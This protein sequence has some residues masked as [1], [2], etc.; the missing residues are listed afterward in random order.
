MED[1]IEI[2]QPIIPLPMQYN[3]QET[4]RSAYEQ[5]ITTYLYPSNQGNITGSASNRTLRW[6]VSAENFLDG[7][8]SYLSLEA[9]LKNFD[10]TGAQ[11]NNFAY[12]T[13]YTETW[14]KSLTIYSNSGLLISQTRN[15]NVLGAIF[16]RH[17][18]PAYMNSVGVECLSLGLISGAMTPTQATQYANEKHKY[19][20]E[21]IGSGFLNSDV[22][23]PLKALA[24]QNSNA[25]QFEIEFGSTSDVLVAYNVAQGTPYVAGVLPLDYEFTNIVYVMSVVKDNAM[26]DSIMD[27]IKTTPIMLHYTEMRNYSNTIPAATTQITIP[28]SE[29]QENV[30]M[31]VDVFRSSA[32]INNLSIDGTIFMN[33]LLNQYQLQIGQVYINAQPITTGT[34]TVAFAGLET[35]EQFYEYVKGNHKNKC[36]FKGFPASTVSN[37]GQIVYT[38][39]ATTNFVL[40]NDLEIYPPNAAGSDVDFF[41]GLNTKQNPQ[42]L[43][44]LL[45][46]GANAGI[47]QMD[48]F[49]LYDSHCVVQ[50]GEVYILS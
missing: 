36:W 39:K 30:R 5:R 20:I 19:V 48:S 45:K 7:K 42:P 10:N 33:P 26:Q 23:L 24:Q 41:S 12:F 9:V 31:M 21:L 38:D 1:S 44:L 28:I 6:L 8:S 46:M 43:Q 18:E 15:Y 35:A 22:Y 40:M 50:Q 47:I 2:A 4:N 14:I 11:L 25:F 32:N 34:P 17:M 29:F 13:P 49:T 37:A 27:L 16:R 3:M